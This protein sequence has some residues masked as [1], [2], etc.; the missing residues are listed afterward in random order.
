MPNGNVRKA[1]ESVNV[2]FS[3][4]TCGLKMRLA[5]M[6]MQAIVIIQSLTG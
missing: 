2:E 5:V 4:E 6:G 3:R 1:V